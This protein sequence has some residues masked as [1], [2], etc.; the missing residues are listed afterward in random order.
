MPLSAIGSNS[1]YKIDIRYRF[2]LVGLDYL[3]DI[4]TEQT[5]GQ[6]LFLFIIG[7][8]AGAIGAIAG[9]VISIGTI[10]L[11]SV[12]A[13]LGLTGPVYANLTMWRIMIAITMIL[14]GLLG[15]LGGG[16]IGG[17]L[18]G[19]ILRIVHIRRSYWI[20]SYSLMSAFVWSMLLLADQ[21][22]FVYTMYSSNIQ[23]VLIWLGSGA[24]IGI[25][26]TLIS[27]I[28]PS[29]PYRKSDHVS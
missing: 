8:V 3:G 11:I 18:H 21:F 27:L 15:G 23:M 12:G 26:A 10:Y 19:I 13:A 22:V 9:I 25:I 4:M 20:V 2:G 6:W 24:G 17:G 7:A 14:G 16:I 29:L 1:S 5:F 28:L